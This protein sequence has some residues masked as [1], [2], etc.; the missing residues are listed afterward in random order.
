MTT[1][2][3]NVRVDLNHTALEPFDPATAALRLALVTII[4][5]EDELP[6]SH[7]L[8]KTFEQ[9]NVGGDLIA[10][11]K[12]TEDYRAAG[13]R[14]LSVGDVVVVAEQP[15]AVGRFGWDPVG[16]PALVAAIA[17]GENH[18]IPAVFSL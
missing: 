16:I 18:P 1:T 3:L 4:E 7:V 12:Y 2:K 14:S 17:A 13:H 8:G 10:A 5:V 9:L 11:T 15:W 6:V